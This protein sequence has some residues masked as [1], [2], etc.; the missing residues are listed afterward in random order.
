MFLSFEETKLRK[1]NGNVRLKYILN[2][3]NDIQYRH[4]KYS[5]Y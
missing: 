3:N 5:K 4:S 1:K 2:S